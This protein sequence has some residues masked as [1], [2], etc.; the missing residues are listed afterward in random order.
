M[1]AMRSTSER[2]AKRQRERWP[3]A[4]ALPSIVP[5]VHTD[6]QPAADQ[7]ERR[8]ALQTKLK[9]SEPGDPCEQEAVRI[10]DQ[11]LAM[12]ARHASDHAPRSIQ[13]FPGKSNRQAD[14]TPAGVEQVVADPG[15]PLEPTYDRIWSDASGTTSAA[16]AY[17]PARLRLNR[18]IGSA[19][20]RTPWD[21]ISFLARVN[22]HRRQPRVWG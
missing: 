6:R 3:A 2:N 22:M 4:G 12:P 11:A 9:I 7:W 21:V 17:I 20:G 16:Y 14:A 19:R 8:L 5:K 15:K 1:Q 18:P 10:A 13:R